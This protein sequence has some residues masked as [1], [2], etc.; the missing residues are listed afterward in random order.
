MRRADLHWREREKELD[1]EVMNLLN[2]RKKTWKKKKCS[3]KRL[4]LIFYSL[5]PPTHS[6]CSDHYTRPSDSMN[7]RCSEN[8]PNQS[9][10]VQSK[11]IL[12]RSL[13]RDCTGVEGGPQVRA[14]TRLQLTRPA[15][16]EC[17]KI[18]SDFV[19]R[20][21]WSLSAETA[22]AFLQTDVNS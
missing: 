10:W 12:P 4:Q 13:S 1:H 5:L 9:I 19:Q 15:R 22:K 11:D 7:G 3:A 8:E 20:Q 6:L 21:A 2:G 18:L 14:E 16:D 17:V